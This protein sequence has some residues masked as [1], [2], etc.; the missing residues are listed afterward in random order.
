MDN[1]RLGVKTECRHSGHLPGSVPRL[2]GRVSKKTDKTDFVLAVQVERMCRC[3]AK[4]RGLFKVDQSR[5]TSIFSFAWQAGSLTSDRQERQNTRPSPQVRGADRNQSPS[6]LAS[7]KPR[8]DQRD[9]G[10]SRVPPFFRGVVH[11]RRE[12]RKSD[13]A[14][15]MVPERGLFA[16][17]QRHHE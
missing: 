2:N 4:L 1:G 5:L 10:P 7:P 8:A 13:A 11:L 14:F 3:R 9:W 16:V 17:S 15:P 6:Q 12:D